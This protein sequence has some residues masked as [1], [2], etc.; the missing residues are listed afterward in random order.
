[1][2]ALWQA[3]LC[4]F[5]KHALSR[6]DCLSVWRAQW[7]SCW[8]QVRKTNQDSAVALQGFRAGESVFGVF[9]GHGP[10]GMPCIAFHAFLVPCN[11][12]ENSM[13]VWPASSAAH[14]WH[15]A[16]CL[17]RGMR[18]MRPKAIPWALAVA[19]CAGHHVSHFLKLRLPGVLSR[20]LSELADAREAM[21]QSEDLTHT[22]TDAP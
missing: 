4:N 14:A 7:C 9:D 10:N 1:M 12:T 6:P 3:R 18:P 5:L 15:H 17:T 19:P 21:S 2:E 11:P 8:L 13:A 16:A 20:N 22:P